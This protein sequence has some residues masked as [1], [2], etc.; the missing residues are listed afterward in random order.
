[1]QHLTILNSVN[2]TIIY[3]EFMSISFLKIKKYHAEAKWKM[4]TSLVKFALSARPGTCKLRDAGRM[5]LSQVYY[6]ARRNV[7]DVPLH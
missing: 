3:C 2:L 4:R 6:S 1:M 5:R 7:C